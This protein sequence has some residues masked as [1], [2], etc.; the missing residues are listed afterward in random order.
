MAIC[1]IAFGH[2]IASWALKAKAAVDAVM[3]VRYEPI[4]EK[5]LRKPGLSPLEGKLCCSFSPRAQLEAD[6]ARP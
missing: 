2:H 1:Q 4:A 3:R 5:L 6:V